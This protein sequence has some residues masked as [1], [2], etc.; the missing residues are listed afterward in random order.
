[1]TFGE[2]G[3]EGAR[4]HNLQ[5]IEAILDIFQAHGHDEVSELLD[6]VL[7]ALWVAYVRTRLMQPE[8]IAGVH[9]RN[10]SVKSTGKAVV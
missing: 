5:D 10:M 3:E 8:R 9:A 4:V 6:P 7:T 2:E 1:M